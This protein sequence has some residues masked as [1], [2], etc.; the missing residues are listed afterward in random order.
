[1]KRATSITNVMIFLL[2]LTCSKNVTIR[3]VQEFT[4]NESVLNIIQTD[5]VLLQWNIQ[6]ECEENVAWYVIYYKSGKNSTWVALDTISPEEGKMLV[7]QRKTLPQ[8]DSIFLFGIRA[9]SLNGDTSDFAYSSEQETIPKGG[10]FLFW[11]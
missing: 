9:V 7:I 3:A 6:E 10:W 1:M 11:K 8:S 5:S 2:S 4:S